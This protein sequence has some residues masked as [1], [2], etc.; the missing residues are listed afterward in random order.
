MSREDPSDVKRTT[1]AVIRGGHMAV[2]RFVLRVI[3]G[4]DTGMKYVSSGR[5][6]V[7]GTHESADLA[8]TDPTV[9]RFHCE[10]SVGEGSVTIRD[11]GSKNAT[12]VSGLDIT[13]ARLDGTT[14][15]VLGHTEVEF[16]LGESFAELPLATR[17]S[18]GE[19][20]GRAPATRALF[21]QLER[22]AESDVTVLLLGETGTG[23]EVAARAIHEQSSR[24]QGP[25][26]VVDCGAIPHS[27]IDSELFGHEKGAFTG[28]DRRREGAFELASGGTIFLDEIGELGADLQPKL[29]RVLERREVQRIGGTSP[30]P[31]DVR[32]I[33]ATNRNLHT[34]VNAGRFRSDLF[35]R[36]AVL[37]VRIPPLRERL[38]DIP[39]LVS[40]FLRENKLED[41]PEAAPLRDD[42]FQANLARYAWRGNVRELRNYLER[43]LVEPDREIVAG[44]GWEAPPEIDV[45]QKLATVREAWVRYVERRYIVELLEKSGGNVSAA[46]RSAGIDRAHFYR[47]MAAC[48]LR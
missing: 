38:D 29:L 6:V 32:I 48:G 31:I 43:A 47:I 21:A 35:Y 20:V 24:A 39:L 17:E 19:L 14:T 33:A 15:I 45:N 16:S 4:P 7:I 37:E 44:P 8:L 12:R 13:E 10:L 30:T 42:K 23:K 2:R 22:A 28:A 5:P 41:R 25:M 36:L 26:I 34:E 18:F 40:H 46:A 1:A 11:L 3:A 9:S 27:L